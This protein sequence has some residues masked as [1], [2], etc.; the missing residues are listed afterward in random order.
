MSDR[1][2]LRDKRRG[3]RGR[4]DFSAF[5]DSSLTSRLCKKRRSLKRSKRTVVRI[6]FEKC[7]PWTRVLEGRISVAPGSSLKS[8]SSAFPEFERHRIH[9]PIRQARTSEKGNGLCGLGMV[10]ACVDSY[11]VVDP[12]MGINCQ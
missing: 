5:S 7:C 3:E 2:K 4:R 10:S 11:R 6:F 1:S 9:F 8:L 12:S